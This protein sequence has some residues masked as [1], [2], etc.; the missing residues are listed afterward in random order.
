MACEIARMPEK[1]QMICRLLEHLPSQSVEPIVEEL[2][3]EVQW[4]CRHARGNHVVKHLL[5]YG[6][7]AQQQKI[8]TMVANDLLGLARHR[9]AS[10][11]VEKAVDASDFAAS[12]LVIQAALNQQGALLELSCK[13]QS[14]FVAQRLARRPGAEGD[15]VRCILYA[16]LEQL[17]KS[18][19][20]S[21][22][23]DI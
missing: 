11:V 18:K 16:N 6:S 20:G 21:R 23:A 1:Y 4:L 14:Q 5:E 17:S 9:I 22:V 13:R 15:A 10:H 12:S 7:P 19:Y 3:V 8:C 2:L